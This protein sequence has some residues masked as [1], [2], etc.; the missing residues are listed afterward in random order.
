M[1]SGQAHE[2]ETVSAYIGEEETEIYV[3]MNSV[4]DSTWQAVVYCPRN[5]VGAAYQGLRVTLLLTALISLILMIVL[6]VILFRVF[7]SRPIVTFDRTA[8]AIAAGDYTQ[9]VTYNHKNE[10]GSLADSFNY[11]TTRLQRYIDYISEITE[12][13]NNVARGDLRFTLKYHYTGEF[14]P[15]KQALE[16]LQSSLGNLIGTVK[17]SSSEVTSGSNDVSGTLRALAQ[18]TSTQAAT[19]EELSANMSNI[20]EL[21][22]NTNDKTKNA[23]E[24]SAQMEAAAVDTKAQIDSLAEAMAYIEQQSLQINQVVDNIDAIAR[25][26]NILSLN[27]SVEAARAGDAGKGFAIVAGEVRTLAAQSAEAAKESS[28]LIAAT[29]DAVKSGTQISDTVKSSMDSVAKQAQATQQLIGEIA[30]YT[31]KQATST[32][33]IQQGIQH[34]ADTI[35]QDAAVTADTERTSNNLADHAEGLSRLVSKFRL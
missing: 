1:L 11:M 13:L 19:I 5:V 18:T 3:D 16:N 31:Q 7:I 20:T 26:T 28:E 24:L 15:I 27:A 2:N 30:G 10:L 29:I 35:E 12:V 6:V 8:Q 22:D 14:A 25:Q 33:E 34:I 9:K 17:D 23:S 32:H 4:P 21:I